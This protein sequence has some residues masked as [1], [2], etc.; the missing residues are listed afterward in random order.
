MFGKAEL[1]AY[2]GRIEIHSR[3]PTERGSLPDNRFAGTPNRSSIHVDTID[4]D[5]HGFPR[6]LLWVRT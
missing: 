6:L 5:K 2:G 3:A 1:S 4:F